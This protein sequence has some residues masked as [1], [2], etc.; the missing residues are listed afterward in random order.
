MTAF[1]DK[2]KYFFLIAVLSVFFGFLRLLLPESLTN[3]ESEQILSSEALVLGF[4]KQPPL[5]SWI[6]YFIKIIFGDLNLWILTIVKYLFYFLFLLSIFKISKLLFPEKIAFLITCSELLFITYSYDFSRDLTHSILLALISSLLVFFYL[7]TLIKPNYL[8]YSFLG[9]FLGL[10]FLAKYNFFFIVLVLLLTSLAIKENRKI[11]FS[12]K[13]LISF[14]LAFLIFSP[15]LIYLFRNDFSGLS[16]ALDRASS[17]SS[18][19]FSY[20]LSHS[21]GLAFYEIV[22][23]VLLLFT[24]FYYFLDKKKLLEISGSDYLK[25]NLIYMAIFSILVPLLLIIFCQFDK[26]YPKWLSGTMFLIPIAFFSLT[27][28]DQ[29]RNFSKNQKTMFSLSSKLLYLLV[30]IVILS[31]SLVN[32]V[33]G[34]FPDLAG[35]LRKTQYP[36]KRLVKRLL[37]ELNLNVAAANFIVLVKKD[38]VLEGNFKL[39]FE[40]LN[41]E[42]KVLSLKQWKVSQAEFPN[43]EYLLLLSKYKPNTK[44]PKRFRA[45]LLDRKLIKELYIN[46]K[47]QYFELEAFLIRL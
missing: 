34:F 14:G 9:I 2:H 11:L 21:L 30:G 45:R 19:S 41:P 27:N 5:Y 44:I 10:G 24:V 13:S 6:L 20:F 16:Y 43:K 33:G 28:L 36:Y 8:N 38:F 12:F 1:F 35:E 29:I 4:P 23:L 26:F 37:G 22:L 32:I 25:K 15:N 3:D 39:E 42:I 31:I 46:S 17:E 18:F 47:N 7:A 40:Q